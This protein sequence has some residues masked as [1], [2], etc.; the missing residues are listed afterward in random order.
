LADGKFQAAVA[1]HV[2]SAERPSLLHALLA[3]LDCREVVTTNYDLLYEEAVRASGRD[4]TS[5]MPWQSAHGADRWIL[6]L[7][8]DVE[9]E[10]TIVLTR[11]HMVRYD[12]AN[13]PSA[14]V[15][16]SLL[17]TR[18]LLA[19]GVSMTDDNVIRLA[20][21]V[22]EY[23]THYQN[24]TSGTF[25]TVIDSAGNDLRRQLWEGQLD[26][27]SYDAGGEYPHRRGAELLLDRIAMHAARDSS[28]LL[29]ERF[30]GLLQ[31]DERQMARDVREVYRRIPK[32][33]ETKWG[34]LI[35]ALEK[36]GAGSGDAR[37]GSPTAQ[38]R[39]R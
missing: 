19:V 1:K 12:A 26:W 17:L 27:A 31:D 3:G 15:L 14:A 21:E 5:V 30:D 35:H 34:P 11:R 28:W 8:G 23:R 36:L 6:K 33:L 10:E 13:R 7:H 2:G 32:R 9:N 25:G 38:S 20:H 22:Q 29:D 16:Q 4:V 37:T 18:H 24:G 39:L